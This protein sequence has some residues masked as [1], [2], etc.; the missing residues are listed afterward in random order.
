VTLEVF[1]YIIGVTLLPLLGWGVHITW[2]LKKCLFILNTLLDMHNNADEHGFGTGGIKDVIED[3]TRAIKALTHYITW[4][5][6]QR[7]QDPPPP[8]DE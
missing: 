5:A 3:N 1:L 2:N 8:L 7:G 4:S 6:R